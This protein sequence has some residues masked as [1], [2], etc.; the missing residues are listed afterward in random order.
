M[1]RRSWLALPGVI[2]GLVIGAG[3]ARW[4]LQQWYDYLKLATIDP[5][6]LAL[7]AATALGV[8]AFASSMPAR[9]AASVQPIEALRSE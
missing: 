1:I 4:I 5:I 2:V 9:R 3:L 7:G 8:V 6:I